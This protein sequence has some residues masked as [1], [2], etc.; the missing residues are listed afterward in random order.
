VAGRPW[1]CS[2][3]FAL[4]PAVLCNAQANTNTTGPNREASAI[5]FA[6]GQVFS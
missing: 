4:T 6:L 3:E 2:S 5:M 1:Q